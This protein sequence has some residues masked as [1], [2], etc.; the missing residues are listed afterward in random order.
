ME[1][2]RP[3]PDAMLQDDGQSVRRDIL[4]SAAPPPNCQ[5][6]V[7]FLMNQSRLPEVIECVMR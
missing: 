4:V 1:R 6:V 5:A 3:D 2:L 7:E